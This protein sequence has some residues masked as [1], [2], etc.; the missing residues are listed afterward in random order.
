MAKIISTGSHLV[1]SKVRRPG[2]H[3]KS[4]TSK[5]KS[6]KNYKKPYRGQGR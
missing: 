4:K 2:V 3:A 5:L 1:S 6:S